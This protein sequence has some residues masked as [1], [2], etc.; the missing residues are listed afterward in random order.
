MSEWD[1]RL[2]A[3]G[4]IHGHAAELR[5]LL[6]LINPT[7][8]DTV[9]TLGDY[10]NRGPDAKGVIDALIDLEATCNLVPILGN[11][12]E[13]M[14]DARRSKAAEDRFRY[15]GGDQTLQ[16]Y[17]EDASLKSVPM[18]HWLFLERCQ[19]SYATGIFVF[20]H[21]NYCWYSA[22]PDQPPSLLRWTSLNEAA[23]KPHVSGKT[24]IVGH[25]PG[26][27]RDLGFCR[28][29]DTGCGFGGMLTAIDLKFNA[30]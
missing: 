2:I 23:P 18:T 16:S 24:F 10:V 8:R 25:T 3:V 29:V 30:V 20:T 13:M 22:L 9:V 5:E 28:C 21:A 17:S 4:D 27:L 6:D 1:G 15:E 14:L 26:P 11:H 19:D 12:D 7:K